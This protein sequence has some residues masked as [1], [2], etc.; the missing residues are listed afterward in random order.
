MVNRDKPIVQVK[1]PAY[2]PARVEARELSSE[3]Q[4]RVCETIGG[5]EKRGDEHLSREF[6]SALKKQEEKAI[7]G[8]EREQRSNNYPYSEDAGDVLERMQAQARRSDPSTS[9]AAAASV[10]LSRGQR[11]VLAVFRKYLILTDRELIWIIQSEHAQAANADEYEALSDSGARSRR[12][13]LARSGVL[14]D[15]GLRATLS[16]GRLAI[17][18]QYVAERDTKGT[19]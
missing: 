17:R 8:D 18:W 9:H 5:A 13:E 15:S 6:F 2:L 7:M 10:N 16:S 14:M 11:I 1:R 4:A 19:E 3:D 12:C